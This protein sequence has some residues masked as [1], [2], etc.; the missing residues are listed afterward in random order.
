M[1][2][3]RSIR[4][5]FDEGASHYHH[6]SD[7]QHCIAQ[8]LT[9][10]IH[11]HNVIKKWPK[12]IA[13][14]GCGS[15]FVTQS[16]IRQAVMD[17]TLVCQS[18]GVP[19]FQQSM[20]PLDDLLFPHTKFLAL[21]WSFS[22]LHHMQRYLNQDFHQNHL[23]DPQRV[24]FI[25]GDF[26]HLPFG[27]THPVSDAWGV[28]SM[29]FHGSSNLS[30]LLLNL[31]CSLNHLFFALPLQGSFNQWNEALRAI[32]RADMIM[33]L[34]SFSS[35]VD[36]GQSLNVTNIFCYQESYEQV[37]KHPRDYIISLKKNGTHG[38]R[39]RLNDEEM[40]RLLAEL[41]RPLTIN[42]A[43]GFVGWKR[44]GPIHDE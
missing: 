21:D 23:F 15:G 40:R 9:G 42:Y 19:A 25:Q 22:M 26:D 17:R 8:R 24:F 43:I 6:Y 20:A 5:C 11:H 4:Q 10:L 36:L 39:G 1:N 27:Q 32:N 13:D 38:A 44:L 41:P 16:L 34:P 37:F 29:A 30:K 3:N 14:L 7:L 28:S 31:L 33:E 35:L 12:W 2:R 18:F